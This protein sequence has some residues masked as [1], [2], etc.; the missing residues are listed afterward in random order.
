MSKL[1]E[2]LYESLAP[3]DELSEHLN[4]QLMRRDALEMIFGG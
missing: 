3:S 2:L 1:D 4:R